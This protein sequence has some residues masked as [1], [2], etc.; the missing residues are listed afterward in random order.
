[1][2]YIT[3]TSVEHEVRAMIV[4]LISEGIKASYP[5]AEVMPFGSFGTKLYLPDG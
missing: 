1:M 4:Q 5:D 2:K 3:P